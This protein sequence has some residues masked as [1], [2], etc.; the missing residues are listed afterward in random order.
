MRLRTP[1]AGG[2]SL[3]ECA[4]ALGLFATAAVA[5]L[6][7]LGTGLKVTRE[8][9]EAAETTMLAE[10]VQTRLA[11]DPAWPGAREDFFFDNSGAEVRTSAQASFRVRLKKLTAAGFASA[12]FDT[13][14][15]AIELLPHGHQAGIWTL[16]RTRLADGVPQAAIP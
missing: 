10:N 14:R 4:L 11:L 2:F 12:Y 8:A 7:L 16:Q 1:R 13:Y 5:L 3:V 6:G 15:V 9:L